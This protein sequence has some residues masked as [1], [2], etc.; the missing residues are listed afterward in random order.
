[1]AQLGYGYYNSADIEDGR[2]YFVNHFDD[3]YA[4]F[5]DLLTQDAWKQYYSREFLL[6]P[7]TARLWRLPNLRDLPS[8]SDPCAYPRDKSVGNQTGFRGGRIT[9]W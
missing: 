1:M 6:Q 8:G 3:Y 4:D 7:A 2:T 5:G 9:S